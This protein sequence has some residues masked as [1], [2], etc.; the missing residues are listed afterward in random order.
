MEVNTVK[1]M[2]IILTQVKLSEHKIVKSEMN[3]K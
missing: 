1:L 3:F 2:E